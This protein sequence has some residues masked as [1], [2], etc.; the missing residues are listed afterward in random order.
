MKIGI[1]FI[2]YGDIKTKCVSNLD[3]KNCFT[4]KSSYLLVWKNVLLSRIEQ[5]DSILSEN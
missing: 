3:S 5:Q 4:Y 1:N 2:I